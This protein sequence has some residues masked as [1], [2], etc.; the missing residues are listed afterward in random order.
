MRDK[1]VLE[2]FHRQ[3]TKYQDR[4]MLLSKTNDK[5]EALSW[6]FVAD[7]VKALA[8]GLI[9]LGVQSGEK[10]AL[11]MTT[12]AY[13]PIWDLSILAA[14]GINVPIYPTNKGTQVAHIINDSQAEILI[15]G[16][17]GLT[18]EVLAHKD[19]MANLRFLILSFPNSA[20]YLGECEGLNCLSIE[21]VRRRGRE[22]G[23]A[24]PELYQ[25][26]WRTVDSE[27]IASLI[28]TSGTTGNP[29]GVILTQNNFL[30]NAY[31][32]AESIPSPDTH[33][34]LSFLPLSHVLER[35]AGWYYM[36]ISGITIAY[37]E[38]INE[39]QKNMQE[40]RPHLMVSV[41]RLYEKIHH[42]ILENVSKASWLRK[43]LFYWS[44]EVGKERAKLESNHKTIPQTLKWKNKLA[45]K[46]VFQKIRDAFGGRIDFC[47]S[48][49]A[50][51]P[52]P[53]AEFFFAVGIRVLEGYGLT[54]TSPVITCNRRDN[55]RFGSVGKV[56]AGVEVKIAKDGEILARGPNVCKGYYNNPE[57]TSE[58]IDEEGWL[59]T[60]DIGQLDDKGFLFITDRKKDII[61]TAG[62][63]NVAP[64][65]I[66]NLL[67]AD[68]YIAQAMVYGD[69]QP[70]LVAMIVPDFNELK[71]YAL[72]KG[73]NETEIDTLI[74]VEKIKKKLAKRV[75]KTLR[76]LPNYEQVKRILIH[77]KE[78]SLEAEE[79]T[80]TLK[81][82][83]KIICNKYKDSILGIYQ[84]TGNIIEVN[85]KYEQVPES[86][87]TLN[88][89]QKTG[90]NLPS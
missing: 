82:R 46:L 15:L 57:A 16:S 20:K 21:E 84:G 72:H 77:P 8:L 62:G 23:Q 37:A 49:G 87:N 1:T 64:Q 3:V 48:G 24:Q 14:R 41:P 40:I 45:D 36:L 11:M 5:Y 6:N 90:K 7:E 38:G 86:S 50:P 74:K 22:L 70:Y 42:R 26:S 60:G 29:K 78:F 34:S 28:Y 13:W 51:F 55:Y 27:D 75:A 9:S 63:K 18:Q 43:K 52:A 4:A 81:L 54:E 80:P 66:E 32:A 2:V 56:I 73:I 25:E 76:H 39:V 79:L 59:H 61:V 30:S 65:V 35:T 47:I 83:R 33:V 89:D 44:I 53:L 69:N 85:Y 68:R 58:L 19:Q 71:S 67:S 88:P 12:Q 10:V 17:D 31:T